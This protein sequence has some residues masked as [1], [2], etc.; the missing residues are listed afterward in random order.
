MMVHSIAA[1]S[2]PKPALADEPP[3]GAGEFTA[4]D[5]LGSVLMLR[6]DET[7]FRDGDGATHYFKVVSG[8]VRT[9]KLLANGRRHVGDFFLPGDFIGLDALEQHAF[10][11]ESVGETT[12]IR[13]ERGRVDALLGKSPQLSRSLHA[14]LRVEL[15]RA[16]ARMLLLGRMTAQERLA[17]FLLRMAARHRGDDRGR[18]S[19]P[20]TRGDIGDYLGLTTETVCRGFA[21]FKSLGAIAAPSPHHLRILDAEK[22]QAIADGG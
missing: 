7:L 1:V 13:Y 16:Q 19:L 15:S 14:R 11:A 17:C 22:L 2:A 8:A 6:R 3:A 12:L 20:M 10:D 21:Q 5:P 18:V 9:C 4:L